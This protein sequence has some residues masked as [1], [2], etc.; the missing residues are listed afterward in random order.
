MFCHCKKF[1]EV[2]PVALDLPPTNQQLNAA[3]ASAMATLGVYA[4]AYSGVNQTGT[5]TGVKRQ[6]TEPIIAYRAWRTDG[7]KLFPMNVQFKPDGYE[8]RQRMEGD[9]SGGESGIH[10]FTEPERILSNYAVESQT[11]FGRVALWGVVEKHQ[12]GYRAQYAYPQMFYRTPGFSLDSLANAWGVEL[13]L[14]PDAIGAHFAEVAERQAQVRWVQ[15]WHSFI[16]LERERPGGIPI[17]DAAK[18]YERDTANFN[19]MMGYTMPRSS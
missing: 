12:H 9:P 2:P 4:S 8:P 11:V 7:R 14:P 19:E 16:E 13:D 3:Y 15:L 17:L 10:A 1:L 5:K 6:Q 18:L